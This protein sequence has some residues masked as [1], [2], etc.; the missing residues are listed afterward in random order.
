MIAN[1]TEPVYCTTLSISTELYHEGRRD[2]QIESSQQCIGEN[3]AG[4]H[5]LLFF[6]GRDVFLK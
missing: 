6:R 4:M 5:F 3:G 2:R 1:T